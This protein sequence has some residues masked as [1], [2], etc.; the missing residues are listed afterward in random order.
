MF[1]THRGKNVARLTWA[2]SAL[3]FVMMIVSGIVNGNEKDAAAAAEGSDGGS[4]SQS[5]QNPDDYLTPE[6]KA[7]RQV[8]TAPVPADPF[9]E[10]TEVKKVSVPEDGTTDNALYQSAVVRAADIATQY[11]TFSHQQTPEAYVELL[12][13]MRPELREVLLKTAQANWAEVE[14][15]QVTA[16]AK[17]GSIQPK[18]VEFD[19][20]AGRAKVAVTL[21]Q[22]VTDR[23]GE[24][25][26]SRSYVV[27]LH[28][29]NGVWKPAALFGQ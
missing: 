27:E 26:F 5:T 9:T 6:E 10:V 11:A 16:T 25:H 1:G 20:R 3:A 19:P 8:G 15:E 21:A 17:I 14:G 13:D 24:H 28:Q 23:E 12:G 22:D 4:S 2:L 29:E 7:A 18:A